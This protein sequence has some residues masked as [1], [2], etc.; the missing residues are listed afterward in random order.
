MLDVG[1]CGFDLGGE[2]GDGG[3]GGAEEEEGGREVLSGIGGQWH[4]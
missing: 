2:I 4:C 3:G 1:F